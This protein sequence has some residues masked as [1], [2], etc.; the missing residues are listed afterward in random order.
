M[1]SAMPELGDFAVRADHRI[2]RAQNPLDVLLTDGVKHRLASALLLDLD[3]G[4]SRRFHIHG[5]ARAP[6]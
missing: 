4:L 3:R 2:G 6:R 5:T 1:W